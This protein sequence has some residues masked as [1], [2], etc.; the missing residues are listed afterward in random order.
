MTC[1][2]TVMTSLQCL[3]KLPST[4]LHGY[5]NYSVVQLMQW[6][7]H[8]H[9]YMLIDMQIQSCVSQQLC[10]KYSDGTVTILFNQNTARQNLE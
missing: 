5:E 9:N 6:R 2:A 1:A 10:V 7:H 8:T 3:A 4:S